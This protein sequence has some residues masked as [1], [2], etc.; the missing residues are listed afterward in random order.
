MCFLWSHNLVLLHGFL[1]L[2][3]GSLAWLKL[4]S[5]PSPG[6]LCEWSIVCDDG[7]FSY[8]ICI[9]VGSCAF[10]GLI[11]WSLWHG[12]LS[13]IVESLAW[14]RKHTSSRF[15]ASFVRGSLYLLITC[16][17]VT[18]IVMSAHV[19]FVATYIIVET[20]CGLK[21]LSLLSPAFLWENFRNL[22]G[23]E[24]FSYVIRS[25]VCLVLFGGHIVWCSDMASWTLGWSFEF[26]LSI[27]P[28]R[29][30]LCMC[31]RHV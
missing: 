31:L 13:I 25:Y 2:I 5:L 1:N 12:F 6:S 11:V 10:C 17:L 24:M 22:S 9:F 16:F 26:A 8:V 28:R 30:N 18:C 19:L 3:V 21:F 15:K 29:E 23:D 27:F 14:V 20:S 4:L 7:M